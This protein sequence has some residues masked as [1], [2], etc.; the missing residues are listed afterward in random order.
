MDIR[1]GRERA[2]E[3]RADGRAA[4]VAAAAAASSLACALALGLTLG[5]TD[6]AA[7]AATSAA[8]PAATPAAARAAA[9]E[10]ASAEA[11][12]PDDAA[13]SAPAPRRDALAKRTRGGLAWQRVGDMAVVQGDMIV[14]RVGPDGRLRGGLARRGLGHTRLIGRWPDGVMPYGFADGIDAT[15][16][17][18]VLAA[19]EHW[20][21]RTRIAFV[22]RTEANADV[23]DDWVE[24]QPTSGCASFVG[25]ADEQPQPL[26]VES[27]TVGSV[28]HEIGHAVG[29]YHEHTRPDRDM[30]ITVDE[31]QIRPGRE[32]NFEIQRTNARELGPYD[33]GS[34]MHYGERFFA[35]GDAPTIIVPPGEAIGQRAALSDG[36]VRAVDAMYATDLALGAVAFDAGNRVE[37]DV[38]VD[39]LG[40]LGANGL[41]L[42]VEL[43]AG[44]TWVGITDGSGWDCLG[45]GAVL[46]CRR[47]TLPETAP[48]SRFR[49]QAEPGEGVTAADLKARLASRTLDTN[50][51]DNV[52]NDAVPTLGAA[53]EKAAEADPGPSAEPDAT[54]DDERDVAAGSPMA[55]E[56]ASGAASDS[57]APAPAPRSSAG[58][59]G[60][61]GG[62]TAPGSLLVLAA[63][64]VL[65][66]RRRAAR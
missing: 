30:W 20:T 64:L 38:T 8:T 58:G 19:I 39:N 1:P 49:L 22:E 21:E 15:Q 18:A 57:A 47:G 25:R 41:E 14:G 11:Y 7:Q 32:F 42:V 33:Y 66:R 55:T 61:G 48:Q 53:S 27:C 63:G 46:R 31:S 50:V 59:G 35:E 54:R 6:A 52:V 28:I 13:T 62:A 24:F 43:G 16:R 17:D 56:P 36:D 12:A 29:L 3:P 26:F 60:G 45:D 34:I 2:H 44:T 9:G 40:Q 51:A 65:A 10:A 4:A 5:S 37:I 23:Y